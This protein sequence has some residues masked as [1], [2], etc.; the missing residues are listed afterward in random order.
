MMMIMTDFM[1]RDEPRATAEDIQ[2][3][4]AEPATPTEIK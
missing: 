2:A 3:T 4:M 1:N